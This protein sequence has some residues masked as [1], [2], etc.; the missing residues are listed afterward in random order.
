[1]RAW[2]LVT[3]EVLAALGMTRALGM[4]ARVS[5]ERIDP[6]HEVLWR[7][8]RMI[9]VPRVRVGRVAEVSVCS[10]HRAHA[11]RASGFDIAP[12]VTDI[13]RSDFAHAA[14]ARRV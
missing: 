5:P 9:R 11:G 3:V 6:R 2:R 1:M 10:N 4:T 14:C 12:I 7:F 8:D 13:H